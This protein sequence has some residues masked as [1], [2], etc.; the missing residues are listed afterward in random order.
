MPGIA[1]KRWIW[2]ER[3]IVPLVSSLMFSAWLGP[4]FRFILGLRIVAPRDLLY[5]GWLIITLLLSA[6]VAK[7]L[8]PRTAWG[9]MIAAVLGVAAISM[10]LV[11]LS[12][13][14]DASSASSL[15][16]LGRTIRSLA[17]WQ[18]AIPATFVLLIM[19]AAL[20]AKGLSIDW[21]DHD[22]LW[23]AFASGVLVLGLLMLISGRGDPER[24]L[25]LGR[26]VVFFL[27][28]GL[29]ALALL[30]VLDVLA[31]QQPFGK[32][33]AGLN[34]YWLMALFLALLVIMVVGWLVGQFLAPDAV[35]QFVRWF[36]PLRRLIG[37]VISFVLVS[38]VYLLFAA[39]TAIYRLLSKWIG[40]AEMEPPQ[41]TGAAE[42]LMRE[43]DEQGQSLFRISPDLQLA[44]VIVFLVLGA[45]SLFWLVWR[46]KR[47]KATRDDVLEERESIG[48]KQLLLDQLSKLLRRPPHRE[49][50]LDLS[51][52]VGPRR[53]IRLTYQRLLAAAQAAGCPRAPGQ[54]PS[55]Y[56]RV[57]D[58]LAPA[59]RAD[60]HDL[61]EAY[62]AARYGELEPAQAAVERARG[63][64][65]R[66]EQALRE[67]GAHAT[68]SGVRED[69]QNGAL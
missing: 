57:L 30:S 3:G 38:I 44:L 61:T 1:S 68:S 36:D 62:V 20:W 51:S 34:R 56:A 17:Q 28:S 15:V 9:R 5:P 22:E 16:W 41:F 13:Y 55:T 52:V 7:R 47:R 33:V 25:S 19:S 53:A 54:T 42:E 6:S 27:L 48:S 50:F 21:S 46:Q 11:G 29:L 59:H 69:E 32:R 14:R 2:L 23:R 66:L 49:P 45:L 4:L 67:H 65:T 31:I 26:A 10:V 37:R 64:L 60:L 12:P 18:E 63:A 35:A 40:R 8:L 39:L 24:A 58:R 43:L